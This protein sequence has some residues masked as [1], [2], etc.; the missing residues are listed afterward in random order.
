VKFSATKLKETQWLK[1]ITSR[2]QRENLNVNIPTYYS[3]SSYKGDRPYLITTYLPHSIEEYLASKGDEKNDQFV[4]ELAAKMIS[5]VEKFH[6]LGYIHQDINPSSFRVKDDG[7]VY[8]KN[9]GNVT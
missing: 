2:I 6:R 1:D 9:F 5:A 3:N 8:L 4:L 7:E